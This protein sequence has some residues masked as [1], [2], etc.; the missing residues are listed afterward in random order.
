MQKNVLCWMTTQVLVSFG[1]FSASG[2][3]QPATVDQNPDSFAMKLHYPAKEKAEKTQGAVKFYCEV[4]PDGK[5]AHIS[6]LNSKGE[7]HFGIAVEF[8]LYHGRFNPATVDGKPVTVMLG[9]TVLFL[10]S[11]AQPTIAVV[12]ATAEGEKIA[13]MSNYQQ[14]QL[15]DTDALFRRKCFAV[16]D[17][18]RPRWGA[19]PGAVVLANIDGQGNLIGKSIESESPPNGG[20]GRLL[21]EVIGQEH[22]I[23]AQS[24]G[25]PVAGD[26]ELVVDFENMRNPDGDAPIGSLI[27]KDNH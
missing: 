8:A 18:Y 9:G 17:K 4:G 2:A 5:P 22:F 14:P 24:N 1:L 6:T 25:K 11:N 7:R 26:F 21:L 13:T 19:N 27:K 23:P 15:L 20:H 10:I 3:M 16:R 12:L